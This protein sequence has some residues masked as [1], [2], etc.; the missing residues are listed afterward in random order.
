LLVPELDDQTGV[1]TDYDR[2]KVVIPLGSAKNFYRLR[3]TE[4]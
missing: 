2:Y 4:N 1:P 3:G